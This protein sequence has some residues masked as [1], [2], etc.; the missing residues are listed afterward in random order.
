MDNQTSGARVLMA[1]YRHKVE[2]IVLSILGT[3]L[4]LVT[5]FPL[6]IVVNNSLKTRFEIMEN[7][8]A[9]PQSP[10]FQN[11]ITA[12]RQLNYPIALLNSLLISGITAIL[13]I[14][15][16]SMAAWVLVRIKTK[17]SS[18]IL[19]LLIASMLIPFQSVMLPQIALM[20]WLG[21]QNP[22]GLVIAYIGFTA[23][24]AVFLYHGFMKGIP[25]ALEEAAYI[26]G[27]TIAQLY[28]YIIFPVLK[29][30]H[31]TVI[32]LNLMATWN[33]FLLPSLMLGRDE[34]QTLPLRM[35]FFFAGF[36]RQW[37]LGMAGLVLAILPIIIFYFIAQK[38]IIKGITA[39]A[40]KG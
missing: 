38:H 22:I 24:F 36:N 8:L 9:L 2:K 31:I 11:F 5:I 35:F 7:P 18:L 27:C 6:F 17:I 37:N 10:H 15:A 21:L 1:K 20:S 25:I 16:A 13:V 33:D 28:W 32:I 39:G 12:F 3:I 23:P 40:E 29:P 26:D 34:W 4:A 14:V 19:M 30:I